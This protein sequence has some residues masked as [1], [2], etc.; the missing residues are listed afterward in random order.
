MTDSTSYAYYLLAQNASINH[1]FSTLKN[2]GIQILRELDKTY[3]PAPTGT[4]SPFTLSP[5][6]IVS[7]TMN[8]PPLT[9]PFTPNSSPPFGQMPSSP[10]PF[11]GQQ[12]PAF[13]SQQNQQDDLSQIEDLIESIMEE[14]WKE[15]EENILKMLEW[16]NKTQ[17]T[18]EQMQQQIKDVNEDVKSL[19]QAIVGKVGEYDKNMLNVSAQLS[20][21]EKAFSQVL[22]TFV[23]NIHELDKITSR[24][25][26]TK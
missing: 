1:V 11:I 16:K 20:A 24:I 5:K 10:P 13:I 8:P 3:M 26:N 2:D 7:D 17:T 4:D 18:L 25:K 22:P 21:M 12:P 23:E 6:S 14:K 9:Q 19:Q 15:V